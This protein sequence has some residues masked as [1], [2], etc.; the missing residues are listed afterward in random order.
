MPSAL[1]WLTILLLVA[2]ALPH[3][4]GPILIRSKNT[5]SGEPE[6]DEIPDEHARALFPAEFFSTINDLEALG[7]VL[8][9]H[10]SS[11]AGA[12]H[13]HSI[14]SLLVNRDSKT[15]AT[16]V[17][18]SSRGQEPTRILS[19]Y[20]EFTAQFEDGSGLDTTNSSTVKVFKD[21]PDKIIVKIPHLRGASS[22]YRVHSFLVERQGHQNPVLPAAG[23]E[24]ENFRL[25][26]TDSM[27]QLAGMGYYFF[28]ESI[29]RYR[30]TW[31]GAIIAAW[32][33]L[34]PAKPIITYRQAREGKRIASSAGVRQ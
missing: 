12:P 19:S 30:F 24:V 4:V 11:D 34:W 28:E 16:I 2:I 9:V 3:I 21:L 5:M 15:T 29:H 33:S 25:S 20:L 10:L 17:S 7:F 31:K 13:L 6:F 27:E 18:I 14:I 22:L 26:F 8:V 23:H 1:F 32:R